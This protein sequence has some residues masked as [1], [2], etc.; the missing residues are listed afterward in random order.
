MHAYTY[1]YADTEPAA[2]TRVRAENTRMHAYTCTNGNIAPDDDAVIDGPEGHRHVPI[3]YVLA[4]G[5]SHILGA[6]AY[7]HMRR[8]ER[9]IAVQPHDALF[10]EQ[11]KLNPLD[12]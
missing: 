1:R 2:H 12:T 7:E 4:D 6:I 5:H 8:A 10:L 3:V 9:K 11:I